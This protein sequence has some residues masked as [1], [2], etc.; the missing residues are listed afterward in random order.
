MGIALR[1]ARCRGAASDAVPAAQT[2]GSRLTAASAQD[3][4]IVSLL[5]RPL[6]RK[7][8]PRGK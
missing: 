7:P 5:R 1:A 8:L 6:K 2:S 4:Q 3:A